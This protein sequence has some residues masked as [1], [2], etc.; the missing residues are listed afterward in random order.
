MFIGLF[1]VKKWFSY[2][3][4]KINKPKKQ[5]DFQMKTK[6]LIRSIALI[7]LFNLVIIL[8]FYSE[9]VNVSLAQTKTVGQQW[10]QP[11]NLSN[12]GSTSKP[13]LVIDSNGMYH[14]IWLD[15]FEG[16]IYRNSQDGKTWSSAVS[17][18]FPFRKND[19]T[20]LLVADNSGNIH[21][22]WTDSEN[23]LHYSRV[24]AQSFGDASAWKSIIG[25]AESAANFNVA[26][27][28]SGNIHLSYVR[29]VDTNSIQAGIYYRKSKDQGKSW[30]DGVSLYT[31]GYFRSIPL[32]EA[33][34]KIDT[35]HTNEG[36]IV[37][38]VWDNRAVRRVFMA[39]SND[40][41]ATWGSP[42][43][44]DGPQSG[45]AGTI[46]FNVN[47]IAQNNITF[48]IWQKG[49]PINPGSKC[50]Q[51]SKSSLDQGKTWGSSQP[52]FDNSWTCPDENGF[53]SEKDGNL[54]IKSIFQD[55]LY[56]LAWNG[57]SWSNPQI[58]NDLALF[59]NPDTH[60]AV[61]LSCLQT[62]LS[63]AD[64]LNAV[65]CDVAGGGDIW[66]SS[67]LIGDVKQWFSQS[68]WVAPNDIVNGTDQIVAPGIVSDLQGFLHVFWTQSDNL[69]SNDTARIYY[70]EWN[71]DRWS[72]STQIISSPSG[73]ALGLKVGYDSKNNKLYL[74]WADSQNSQYYF[75]SVNTNNAINSSDW[76]SPQAIPIKGDS[77]GS[78][79]FKIDPVLGKIY[80]A[81]SVPI[82]ENR[83]IYL[84]T[85]PDNG[86]TWTSPI[87][88]FNALAA[89]WVFVDKPQLAFGN[90][91]QINLIWSKFD[92]GLNEFRELYY[93]K[94]VNEG[95][96]WSTPIKIV[97]NSNITWSS[98][99]NLSSNTSI[100]FWQE[101]NS[102][103]FSSWS[104][105]SLD[106][107][108]RWSPPTVIANSNPPLGPMDVVLDSQLNPYMLRIVQKNLFDQLLETWSWKDGEWTFKDSFLLSRGSDFRIS[109]FSSIVSPTGMLA[110]I[111]AYSEN[112]GGI[113]PNY[114]LSITSRTINSSPFTGNLIP[115]FTPLPNNPTP[116]A[117]S[118]TQVRTPIPTNIKASTI[119]T[120]APITSPPNTWSGFIIGA[121]IVLILIGVA[122][123]LFFIRKRRETTG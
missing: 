27:D 58:Q 35:A 37:Y 62:K 28:S 69:N 22:F 122:L 92:L 110:S 75:S 26:I 89:G 49:D 31:S 112:T 39:K 20:P 60:Q 114:H 21:A 61:S 91:G 45:S 6:Y 3:Q 43:E 16:Y 79:E 4:D 88:V 85:S 44:V 30:I 121:A 38:V 17:V 14:V 66:F 82:N 13:Q 120:P 64:L 46:P 59:S 76:S 11:I 42:A 51:Y 80:L 2:R 105:Y 9:K 81:Y 77:T 103:Q 119:Q 93:A 23:V 5:L 95:N 84:I 1:L 63:G 111:F 19:N 7:V 96:S 57:T 102:G 71:K 70:K 113:S 29:I 109:I 53:L 104:Q 32:K 115:T 73:N 25:L 52:M 36:D 90:N 123:G 106:G 116:S 15:H 41:G 8:E 100:I 65:G 33:N 86:K 18:S 56:L 10:T 101:E 34:V 107:G 40:A 54:I 117:T 48:L 97:E 78:V 108:N 47:V 74:I 94:S 118:V 87:E 67:Y 99:F 98:I 24:R 12:S 55:Q 50:I 83:G 68:P 72:N